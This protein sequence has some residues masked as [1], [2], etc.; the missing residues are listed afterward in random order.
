M[1]RGELN[2]TSALLTH[3]A[4]GSTQIPQH[5]S[6]PERFFSAS[7]ISAF[8]LSM[9][10]SV[11]S[12]ISVKNKIQVKLKTN[13]SDIT[14]REIQLVLVVPRIITIIRSQMIISRS[15]RQNQ[16][17]GSGDGVEPGAPKLSKNCEFF[18]K[19][20]LHILSVQAWTEH[21]G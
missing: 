1:K 18:I 20:R 21:K 7:T 4:Q 2:N 6:I 11:C 17:F 8:I 14:V 16:S 13:L 3:L 15:Q 12:R 10:F 9:Q 19:L 5:M